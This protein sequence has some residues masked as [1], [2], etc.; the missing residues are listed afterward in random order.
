MKVDYD[1]I[2]GN[3]LISY[4]RGFPG[5]PKV[6]APENQHYEQFLFIINNQSGVYVNCVRLHKAQIV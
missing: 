2:E 6:W 5:H 4:F 3:Y 1:D